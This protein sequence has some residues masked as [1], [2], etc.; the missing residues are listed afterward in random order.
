GDMY[1]Y[2]SWSDGGNRTHTYTVTSSSQVVTAN[3]KRQ[4]YLRVSSDHGNPQGQNWYDAG[5]TAHF[6]VTSPDVEGNTRYVLKN[7][8]GN[9]TGTSTSGSIVMNSPKYLTALWQTQHYLTT[10]ENPDEGGDMTPAPPGAW[11]DEGTT[12]S[13]DVTVNDGY[14]WDGWSGDLTGTTKPTTITMDAPKSV[15]ANFSIGGNTSAITIQTSPSGLG[16][17]AD[18]T[19][20]TA[21][22]TFTWA[23][24]S[25]HT[26]EVSSPQSGA[27]GIRYVY[28]SWSDGGDQ[29]HAYTVPSSD[30]TVTAN[31]TTQYQLT[32]NSSYGSPTGDGWYDEG[33]SATFAVTTPES[34][35]SG[36][37]YIFTGWTGTGEGSYTGTEAS[38]TVTM[39]NPITEDASWKTQYYL[40]TAENPDE[41]G[42]ITP[43]PPGAWYDEGATASVDVTVNDGYKWDGWSGDLTG[44]T[45]PTTITMDAPKS[46][47]ANF[48]VDS[49]VEEDT[50]V[51][52]EF[53]LTQ[54]YP[55]PFNPETVISYSTPKSAQVR[56]EIYNALGKK[57]RTLVDD[58][59]QAGQHQIIWDG[60]NDNGIQVST[61]IYYY[62]MQ[63]GSFRSM[64]KAVF[65]K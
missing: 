40:T 44:T 25:S 49:D 5:T 13:V 33:T 12:A 30:E 64:K 9:Y 39:N 18:G 56:I 62:I 58:Y 51:P 34:G 3:F 42:D 23:E 47:T 7:W 31:F 2:V 32:V 6:S 1:S 52:T 45:K 29:S 50:K 24:G 21:P 37:R 54:N 15:T 41:G 38:Y 43:A 11:Y 17:T 59:V 27:S 4:Y 16:F 28:S 22:H 60:K 35:S 53:A 8:T 26:I 48:S 20:Y 19:S 61:G 57:I 10:S 46:V 63:S 36:T 55:N 14:I 65:M